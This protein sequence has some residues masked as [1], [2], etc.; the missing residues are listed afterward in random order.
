M[1]PE[2]AHLLK[3]DALDEIT[4]IDHYGKD[5]VERDLHEVERLE[6]QFQHDGSDT[7]SK[8][9]EA[10]VHQHVE[11]SQLA[12]TKCRNHTCITI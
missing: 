12:R 10:I 1:L 3:E 8:V 7:A 11:L 2:A 9:F 5:A 4:F 6:K